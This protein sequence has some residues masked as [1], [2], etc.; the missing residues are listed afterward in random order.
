[1]SENSSISYEEMETLFN[2]GKSKP[3]EYAKEKNFI[4]D[5]KSINLKKGDLL[6]NF[7]FRKSSK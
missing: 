7:S 5:I 2:Q 4:D 3:A 6:F 1:V